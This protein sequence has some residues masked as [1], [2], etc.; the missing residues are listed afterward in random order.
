MSVCAGSPSNPHPDFLTLAFFSLRLAEKFLIAF[1]AIAV[2]MWVFR[3]P[4]TPLFLLLGTQ[5]LALY[6]LVIFPFR[7]FKGEQALHFGWLQILL[8]VLSGLILALALHGFML[9]ALG[10]IGRWDILGNGC[11]L[12]ALLLLGH[13]LSVWRWKSRF[14]FEILIRAGILLFTVVALS[15]S[16]APFRAARF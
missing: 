13:G 14:S 5:G 12:L 16:L 2:G 6:Y 15:T 9:Y 11:I 1:S 4:I 10:W 7:K 8:R 3:A